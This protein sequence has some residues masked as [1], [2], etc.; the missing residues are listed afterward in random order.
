MTSNDVVVLVGCPIGVISQDHSCSGSYLRLRSRSDPIGIEK[1]AEDFREAF[2]AYFL[3]LPGQPE[4]IQ[5]KLRETQDQAV[6][7]GR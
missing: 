4:Y 2:F 6:S 3:P 1:I 5:W 7:Q